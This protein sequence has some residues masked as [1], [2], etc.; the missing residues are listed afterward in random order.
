[1]CVLGIAS[2]PG[3][4]SGRKGEFRLVLTG[5]IVLSLAAGLVA[6]MAGSTERPA[7]GDQAAD[8]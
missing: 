1:M 2:S 4:G 3:A 5:I 7:T 8:L 6:V